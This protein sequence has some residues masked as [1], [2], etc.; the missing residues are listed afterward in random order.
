MTVSPGWPRRAGRSG[1]GEGRWRCSARTPRR[2][3]WT[4]QR[5]HRHHRPAGLR[6]RRPAMAGDR[7]LARARRLCSVLLR[8]RHGHRA[9]AQEQLRGDHRCFRLPMDQTQ[10]P[11]H[12][13]HLLEGPF[14]GP[15]ES[16]IFPPQTIIQ[17]GRL[18]RQLLGLQDIGEQPHVHLLP[19]AA[20]PHQSAAN[21]RLRA[22]SHWWSPR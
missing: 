17:S 1:A 19:R 5:R 11:A 3:L 12:E 20:N 4:L 15:E 14:V 22:W 2:G 13:G 8:S 16:L 21:R 7:R 6:H 10:R 18:H 9:S